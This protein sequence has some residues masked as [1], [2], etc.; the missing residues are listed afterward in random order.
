MH[1][2]K[3]GFFPG[4]GAIDDIG[5]GKGIGKCLNLPIAQKI[6]GSNFYDLF[7][8]AFAS[9]LKSFDPDI[10]VCVC[11]ADIL[12]DDPHAGFNVGSQYYSKCVEEIVRTDIPSVFLG[13]GISMS[14]I[15]FLIF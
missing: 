12:S 9:I 5:K 3:A 11:G 13:G 4:T 7:R 8:H 15:K 2:F 6:N 10:I 14:I 1:K